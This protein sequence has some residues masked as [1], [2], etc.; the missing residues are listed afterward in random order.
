MNLNVSG[1]TVANPGT[2]PSITLL[3]G[4]RI[5][6]GVDP[7]DTFNTCVAFGANS[8]TGSSDAANK[9]FRLVV[10]QST[11]LR[12]PGYVGGAADTAAFVAYAASKIGVAASQGTAAANAPG[13]FGGRRRHHLSVTSPVRHG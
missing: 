6:S 7:G 2:N 13:T 11:V 1:N 3:Q 9:D 10:S 5:D 4:I 8:I 12:Q